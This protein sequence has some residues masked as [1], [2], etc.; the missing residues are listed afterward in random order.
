MNC[1]A[2]SGVLASG[3]EVLQCKQ[4]IFIK[5]EAVSLDITTIKVHPDGNGALKKWGTTHRQIPFFYKYDVPA[6]P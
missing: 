5:I 4:I 1:W 3:F 2:K 6:Y